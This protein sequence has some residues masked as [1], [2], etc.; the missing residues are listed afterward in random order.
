MRVF[1]AKRSCSTG[2]QKHGPRPSMTW[3]H[4]QARDGD[5]ELV[6]TTLPSSAGSSDE[7]RKQWCRIAFRGPRYELLSKRIHDQL[8]SKVV[9]EVCP[10]LACAVGILFVLGSNRPC[11]TTVN[12]CP[13]TS[14]FLEKC[15]VLVSLKWRLHLVF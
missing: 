9:P 12:K 13:T 10:A 7:D 8:T 15:H 2:A 6:H 5:S 14:N 1:G 11:L 4:V 3:R